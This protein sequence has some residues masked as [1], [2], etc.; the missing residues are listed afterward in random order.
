MKLNHQEFLSLSNLILKPYLVNDDKKLFLLSQMIMGIDEKA[1]K[2]SQ[3]HDLVYDMINLLTY[4]QLKI[5]VA[6][7]SVKKQLQSIFNWDELLTHKLPSALFK[8]FN[9]ILPQSEDATLFFEA[10]TGSKKNNL[11]YLEKALEHGYQLKQEDWQQHLVH[12]ITNKFQGGIKVKTAFKAYFS[13]PQV[14]P[15]L[16]LEPKDLHAYMLNLTELMRMTYEPEP[17]KKNKQESLKEKMN[18]I[19]QNKDMHIDRDC[20][21]ALFEEF[22]HQGFKFDLQSSTITEMINTFQ[23]WNFKDELM[24]TML[25]NLVSITQNLNN[26]TPYLDKKEQFKKYQYIVVPLKTYLEKALLEDNIEQHYVQ[27]KKLKI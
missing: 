5:V 2:N 12:K 3:T 11:T 15:F 27:K 22:K 19:L 21:M 9:L 10:F 16:Y 24:T 25:D 8:K 14:N 18:F 20:V 6:D 13:N 1:L 4:S 26:F 17:F 7:E 23:G